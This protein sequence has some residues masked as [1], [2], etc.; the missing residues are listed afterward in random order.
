MPS[1]RA[2]LVLG[3]ADL[4]TAAL[5][6]FGVFVGLP[7]RWWPV[8][9]AAVALTALEVA[10]GIGLLAKA[11]W[12]VRVARTTGA[13]ALAIGLFTVTALAMTASWLS[14]VY[15]PVGRGGAIVLALVAVLVLPYLVVLPIAQ[16]LWLQPGA[17]AGRMAPE[18]S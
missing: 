15:G 3:I 5:V 8:D 11:R 9:S 16:L 13:A 18:R 10:S 1:R 4:V 12:A 7:T 17:G 14:G 2:S 6:V